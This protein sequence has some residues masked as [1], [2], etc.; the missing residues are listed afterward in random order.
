MYRIFQNTGHSGLFGRYDYIRDDCGGAVRD[1][2]DYAILY[3]A[4]VRRKWN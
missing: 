2:D 3:A 1:V 4:I